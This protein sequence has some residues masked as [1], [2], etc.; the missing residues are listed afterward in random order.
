V[1]R[2]P[3]E[4][5]ATTFDT[6]A[7]LYQQARPGYPRELFDDLAELAGLPAPG[8]RV[9]EIGPGTGQA[10]RSL[11]ARGW[12]VV[13]LEPGAA[14]ASVARRELAGLG[15]VDVVEQPFEVWQGGAASYD[16]VLAAT[17]WHW[18]DP[19]VAYP[20]A[21]ALLRPGGAL[22][23]VSTE[24]V[25]PEDDGDLFLRAVEEDY[26]AVGLGDGQ[27]GPKPPDALPS[28]DA[29]AM[30]ATGL[31]HEPAVR[32]YVWHRAYDAEQ[33]I[34]LL[35]TYSGHIAATDQQRDQLFTAIRRRIARQP[36]GLVRK[37]FLNIVV[38]GRRRIAG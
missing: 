27:G 4:G 37:H 36:D 33:Y 12:R 20:K 18:L 17:A 29:D 15:D 28:P 6:A 25:L 2:V 5:L 30:A 34:A 9:V 11:L 31:F 10:T 38:I 35:R 1:S 16:L 23:I 7:E 21:A 26:D 19:E 22:A 13:G 14:L 3:Y 8:A 24:H 32:R